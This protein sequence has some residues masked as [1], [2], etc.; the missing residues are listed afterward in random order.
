MCYSSVHANAPECL[1]I[2]RFSAGRPQRRWKA[3]L[4]RG[5]E[6]LILSV[7]VSVCVS[8]C[9]S[10]EG[11]SPLD[12]GL[13]LI[14]PGL[15]S[16][17]R[18]TIDLENTS[19]NSPVAFSSRFT[20]FTHT[21]ITTKSGAGT[22]TAGIISRWQC[23]YTRTWVRVRV[24]GKCHFKV[25]H[26]SC[27]VLGL[28]MTLMESRNDQNSNTIGQNIGDLGAMLGLHGRFEL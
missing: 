3:S 22:Q 5:A 10:G 26:T 15:L 21:S 12:G 9:L 28:D 6:K 1:T 27:Q 19:V 8:V 25:S 17:A 20:L 13:M 23:V 18:R 14:Q 4:F 24:K 7:C 2:F 11:S 16:P